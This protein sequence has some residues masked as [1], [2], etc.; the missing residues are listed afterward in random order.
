MRHKF[1]HPVKLGGS[2][3]Q[4]QDCHGHELYPIQDSKRWMGNVLRQ[5]MRIVHNSVVEYTLSKVDQRDVFYCSSAMNNQA[6][7]ILLCYDTWPQ[8]DH[9]CTPAVAAL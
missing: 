1:P 2:R 8:T 7:L 6:T 5:K 3:E 4:P 9:V